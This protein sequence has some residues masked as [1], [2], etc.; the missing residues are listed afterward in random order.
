MYFLKSGFFYFK[1]YLFLSQYISG[2]LAHLDLQ[3]EMQ[4]ISLIITSF[5]L[6]LLL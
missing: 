4:H 2:I 3:Y 5:L 6:F 1:Y